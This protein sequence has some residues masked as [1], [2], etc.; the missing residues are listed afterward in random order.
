MDTPSQ[1]KGTRTDRVLTT[2]DPLVKA[3]LLELGRVWPGSLAFGELCQR[4][5]DRLSAAGRPID[6]NSASLRLAASL[7]NCYLGSL[8]ELSPRTANFVT[9]LSE[10]P[11]ACPL[12]R[13]QATTA[14]T[15]TNRRHEVY[16]VNEV[17]RC[18]L[19]LLDGQH[20]T[21]RLRV[22]LVNCCRTG[23]LT[24]R[25]EGTPVTD[26]DQLTSVVTN[27][28]PNALAQFVRSALLIG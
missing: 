10:R 17:E 7:L 5:S 19:A 9:E 11:L 26:P 21:D 6:D 22:E 8:V 16:G 18:L 4:A 1:F 14:H 15:V 2:P 20:D 23:Q 25:R 13:L 24:A 12:V 27:V 28:L 3:A